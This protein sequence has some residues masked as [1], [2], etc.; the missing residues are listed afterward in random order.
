[1]TFAAPFLFRFR[2][3]HGT[4]NQFGVNSFTSKQQTASHGITN[5]FSRAQHCLEAGLVVVGVSFLYL[6]Q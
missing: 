3:G 2:C 6:K 4:S 1:M 5:T